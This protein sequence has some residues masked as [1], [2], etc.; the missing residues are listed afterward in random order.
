MVAAPAACRVPLSCV[1]LPAAVRCAVCCCLLLLAPGRERAISILFSPLHCNGTATPRARGVCR[2]VHV[3]R[4][5]ARVGS[6]RRNLDAATFSGRCLGWHLLGAMPL[7][8][9]EPPVAALFSC[10]NIRQ[11]RA[12][13]CSCRP[14]APASACPN[15]RV[16][17]P[18][19]QTSCCPALVT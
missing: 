8:F 3:Q 1:L 16:D 15:P 5:A 19:Q 14:Q 11:L 6:A 4:A 9:C 7:V 12:A 13:R 10:T 18:A 2:A 17:S